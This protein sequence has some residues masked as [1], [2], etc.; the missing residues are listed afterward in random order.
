MNCVDTLLFMKTDSIP[1]TDYAHSDP[2]LLVAIQNPH[3]DASRPKPRYRAPWA[4]RPHW[5]Y[6]HMKD[7]PLLPSPLVCSVQQKSFH[8]LSLSFLLLLLLVSANVWCCQVQGQPPERSCMKS[9]KTMQQSG[10]CC[11]WDL[12]KPGCQRHSVFALLLFQ[13][14]EPVDSPHSSMLSTW[15]EARQYWNS[16][17]GI[18]WNRGQFHTH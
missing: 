8:N 11:L 1:W 10:P 7:T 16:H 6:F 12:D 15:V 13:Y 2:Q 18:V 5:R 9:E 4:P 17:Q 14:Q 3:H